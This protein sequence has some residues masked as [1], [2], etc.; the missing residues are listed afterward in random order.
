MSAPK[1]ILFVDDEPNILAG[2]RRMLADRKGVWDLCFATG[3]AEGLDLIQ[4]QEFDVVVTD[5]TMP[6]KDGFEL[7]K[8]LR[9]NAETR[10]LPVVVLTG[11]GERNI[12][13]KAL[14]LGATDLLTK[15][16]DPEDLKARIQSC[17]LQKSYLDEIKGFNAT[18]QDKVR[19]RTQELA[20]SRLDMILRLG[21][22]AEFREKTS[23]SHGIKVGCYSRAIAE[24]LGLERVVVERLFVASPLHDI[25]KIGIPEK[26]LLKK[27]RLAFEEWDQLKSHCV[28]GWEILTRKIQGTSFLFSLAGNRLR[29]DLDPGKNPL[30]KMASTIA[31]THHEWWNGKG[32]PHR[33]KGEDIPLE[34]RIVALADV[35]DEL[36]SDHF[37][38]TA[39]SEEEALGM[40][41]KNIGEQF[42][43]EI[44][45]AFDKSLGRIREI[46][47]Q[48]LEWEFKESE[49]VAHDI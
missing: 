12:K 45:V 26:I 15:P 1:K 42:D 47:K 41:R 21:F 23:G 29:K 8:S 40:I 46:R 17:L 43:P 49:D 34:S 2:I 14:D 37:Y 36:I 30:V 35:Y 18:L 22:L 48:F 7:L 31:L 44:Y 38:Q 3:A 32:Y 25:G 28:I 10:A 39:H 19:E 11:L 6:G 13:R 16:V 9:Q 4:T 5:I 24:Q 20:Q 33:L 27:D